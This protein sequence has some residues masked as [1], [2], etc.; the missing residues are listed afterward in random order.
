MVSADGA[1]EVSIS[2]EYEQLFWRPWKPWLV[3]WIA[4]TVKETRWTIA[5]MVTMLT[6]IFI[7]DLGMVRFWFA[8][9]L[10]VAASFDK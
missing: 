7:T 3:G 2:M 4:S 8:G 10:L 1:H 5:K 6:L 9:K